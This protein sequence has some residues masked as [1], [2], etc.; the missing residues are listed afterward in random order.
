MHFNVAM[1]IFELAHNGASEEEIHKTLWDEFALN[2]NKDTIH[3]LVSSIPTKRTKG[4]T[5]VKNRTSCVR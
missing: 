3:E 1:R 4:A 5:P 2:E